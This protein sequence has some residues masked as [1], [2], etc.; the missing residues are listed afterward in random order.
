MYNTAFPAQTSLR[1]DF[2]TC[3][4]ICTMKLK[5]RH[6]AVGRYIIMQPL[7]MEALFKRNCRK[8][9]LEQRDTSDPQTLVF[10]PAG[11]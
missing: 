10:N 1:E 5:Q 11:S 2:T 6:K 4:T 3:S 7:F 9:R 8:T